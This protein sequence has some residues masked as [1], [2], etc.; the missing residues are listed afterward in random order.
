MVSQKSKKIIKKVSGIPLSVIGVGDK[1]CMLLKSKSKTTSHLF[2]SWSVDGLDFVDDKKKVVIESSGGKK[3]SVKNCRNF[4][5]S[6]TSTG[7][8]MVYIRKGKVRNKDVFVV[9]KSLDLYKWTVKSTMPLEDSESA[10]VLYN[11]NLDTFE[12]YRDGLFVKNQSSRTLNIWKEKPSLLFTT[13]F[14]MFDEEKISIIGSLVTPEG[15]L[16]MY[17]ASLMKDQHTLLQAGGVLMNTNDPKRMIWRSEAPLWQ[18]VV[19]TKSKTPKATPIGFVYYKN[20]YLIYWLSDNGNLVVAMFPAL[21][22]NVEIVQYKI[23]SKFEKNP[24]LKPRMDHDWEYNGTFNPAVFQ[25]D[26]GKI[27][28]L[29]RALGQDGI[30]RVG[31]ARSKD[32]MSFTKRLPYPI[33]EPSRGYGMPD[34]GETKR[35]VGFHPAIYTSGGGWGGSEDPRVVKIGNRVYMIYV[36]FEGWQSVR[37]AL[38][39]ISIQDFREGKWNWKKPVLISP[40][41][42][43]NKNWLIFPEK[44]NGKFAVL[45]SIAPKVMIEYVNDLDNM[46]KYIVSPRMEGPQPG[47]EGFW[48]SKLRGAGPPPLKT[49]L[50][51]LL[52]YHALDKREPHKYK[53]GAMLLDLKDPTKVLYRSNHPILYPE[54]WY[55]NEGKP[56]VVYASGAIIKG[57]DLYV[58]YGGG[59]RVVCVATTNLKELLKY[60]QTGKPDNFELQKVSVSVQ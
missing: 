2:L 54:M 47:R 41:G 13:R 37:I 45:H 52:L 53:L 11:K 22:K 40:P 44:I 55:E 32:G 49:E 16:V 38:T 29:Y 51:W 42:H 43:A 48:D 26:D 35:P 10:T 18:G 3:E 15:L 56:G 25:D 34:R 58:Y 20:S 9:A 39:S 7:F 33:F 5:I 50:G 1:I 12:F 24:I 4:S 46:E 57:E 19:E 30:S 14:G 8:V 21:F 31:Y 27:H 17:D 60:L 36:A 6:V 28:L 23:L 59:D